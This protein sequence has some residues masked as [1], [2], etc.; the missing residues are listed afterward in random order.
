MNVVPC[1]L[2]EADPYSLC[3]TIALEASNY[4]SY[5]EFVYFLQ[6]KDSPAKSSSADIS[7]SSLQPKQQS[8]Q[9]QKSQSNKWSSLFEPEDPFD[10]EQPSPLVHSQSLS[11]HW[12]QTQDNKKVSSL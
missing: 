3:N 10:L 12:K 6:A 9:M 2:A 8:T 11:E 7:Q 4:T 1:F 5:S